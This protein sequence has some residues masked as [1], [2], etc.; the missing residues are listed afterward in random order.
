MIQGLIDFCGEYE[1]EIWLEVLLLRDITDK[2][3]DVQ[4]IAELGKKLNPHKIQINTATRPSAVPF[5]KPVTW[6]RLQELKGI[7]GDKSEIIVSPKSTQDKKS[8]L[9]NT[10]DIL[11]MLHRR[12]CS[13]L[14]V[15]QGLC[16]S[17]DAT[18]AALKEMLRQNLIEEEMVQDTIYYKALAKS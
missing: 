16:I 10:N 4:K 12:P 17:E 13:L 15:A 2:P 6:E 8:N 7:F 9:V 3:E 18:A 14:D 5:S 1:G 11:S